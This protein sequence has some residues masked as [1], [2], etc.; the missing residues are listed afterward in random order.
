MKIFNEIKFKNLFLNFINEK[1]VKINGVFILILWCDNK[2]L[3]ISILH[4]STAKKIGVLYIC[5]N[6]F[7]QI[8]IF[9]ISLK[10]WFPIL[11]KWSI[12]LKNI[13]WND[14]KL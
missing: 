5:F 3:I 12:L 7:H 13:I 6:E 14:I 9:E 11:F 4:F 1:D 2:S 8:F 10:N